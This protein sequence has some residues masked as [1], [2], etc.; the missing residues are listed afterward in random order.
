[1]AVLPAE[2]DREHPERPPRLV[3][4]EPDDRAL[5]GGVAEPRQEIRVQ[6]A[7]MGRGREPLPRPA[8]AADP[9]RRMVEGS[10]GFSPNPR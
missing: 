5:Q 6:G 7:A 9:D 8:D 10:A 2:E 3:G 1:V 4:D